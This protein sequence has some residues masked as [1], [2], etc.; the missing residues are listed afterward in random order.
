M[1]NADV[2][3]KVK[4]HI[5]ISALLNVLVALFLRK[6]PPPGALQRLHDG[7]EVGKEKQD[8]SDK[9]AHLTAEIQKI[10][11]ARDGIQ[12]ALPFSDAEMDSVQPDLDAEDLVFRSTPLCECISIAP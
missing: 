3:T 2:S 11:A 6:L 8:A 4:P 10:E 12:R 9:H 5:D 1:G 7:V